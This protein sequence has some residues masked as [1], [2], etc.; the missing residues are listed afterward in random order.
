MYSVE[1]LDFKDGG[2]EEEQKRTRSIFEDIKIRAE[3]NLPLLEREKDFFCLGL[4]ASIV[5]ED[6][7]LK[8]YS[9][10][11]NYIFKSLYLTYYSG[12]F[13]EGKFIKAR[14]ANLYEVSDS[15]KK[16]DFNYLKI[17]EN[18]WLNQIQK[19]NHKEELLLKLSIE[20]RNELKKLK[21]ETG[22]LFFRKSKEK[23][24]FR[25]AKIILHSK[26]LYILIKK[27]KQDSDEA[28]FLFD[29]CGEQIE[30]DY[31][32]LVHIINRHYAKII[33]GNPDKSYHVEEFEPKGLHLRLKKIMTAINSSGIITK[34]E[35][36]KISF[37]YL[38]KTYRVWIKKRVKQEKGIGNVDFYRLE[39]FFPLEDEKELEELKNDYL[40][41]KINNEIQLYHKSK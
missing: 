28:D 41:S 11:E 6:G 30:I 10:C 26:Y 4:T 7:K 35:M 15:E 27:I 17:V 20:T 36:E 18:K 14:K 8:G 37:E 22:R 1:E 2:R 23:Y 29:F 9:I 39:T 31:Y 21:K 24:A 3:K 34:P 38:N 25:K 5:K 32:T 19:E 33:K 13:G 16:S 12:A 40:V